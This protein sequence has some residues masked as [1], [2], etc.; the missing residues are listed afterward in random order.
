MK[1]KRIRRWTGRRECK[2]RGEWKGDEKKE[3][4][5]ERA[6]EEWQE[7]GTSAS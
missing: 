2:E 4:G 5:K 3:R 7:E 1:G 6:E